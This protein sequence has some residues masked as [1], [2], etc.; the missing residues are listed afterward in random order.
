MPL[1]VRTTKPAILLR[2]PIG[3]MMCMI[4]STLWQ[5]YTFSPNH[6]SAEICMAEICMDTSI[7]C[8]NLQIE[9]RERTKDGQ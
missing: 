7:Q 8:Q 4:Y 3:Q 5:Q 1:D 6:N 9:A 2:V